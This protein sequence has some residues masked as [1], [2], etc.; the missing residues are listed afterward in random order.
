M[1]RKDIAKIIITAYFVGVA[2]MVGLVSG[3]CK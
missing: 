3:G 2:L 1:S